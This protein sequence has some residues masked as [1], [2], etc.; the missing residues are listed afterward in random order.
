M[1]RLNRQVIKK[2]KKK[3]LNGVPVVEDG[4]NQKGLFYK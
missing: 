1:P 2:N 3:T 4:L